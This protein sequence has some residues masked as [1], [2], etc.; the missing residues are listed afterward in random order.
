M[1]QAGFFLAPII[2]PLGILPERFHFYLYVWPP[3]PIIEFSRAALVSGVMPT[4][5]G[6]RCTWRL[7]AASVC[8]VVG[9]VDLPA[10]GPARR[11]VRLTPCRSSKWTRSPRRFWI[12]SVQARDGARAR[13]RHAA[14]AAVRAAP[15]ARRGQ[16]RRA[17]GRGARHHGAQRLRQEHAA[18]DPVRHLPAR[19]RPGDQRAPRSRR[20]SSSASAGI[21]SSTRSTT[22]C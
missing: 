18:E 10:A 20:C 8:L 9:I 12:P 21:P 22:C 2:Y 1:L 15:G 13:A 11:G 5:D 6:A 4:R 16:L 17:R 14:A 19:P 7:D 3:T